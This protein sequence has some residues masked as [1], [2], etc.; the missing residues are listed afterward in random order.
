MKLYFQGDS[1]SIRAGL[2]SILSSCNGRDLS[3]SDFIYFFLGL[4]TLHSTGNPINCENMSQIEKKIVRRRD[5]G[6]LIPPYIH[7]GDIVP[8][9]NAALIH[10]GIVLCRTELVPEFSRVD[11]RD[12]HAT[13]AT[14]RAV[15]CLEDKFVSCYFVFRLFNRTC[16]MSAEYFSNVPKLAI[17]IQEYYLTD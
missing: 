17:T 1:V 10:Q 16:A 15:Y 12:E 9:P 11:N 5:L 2:F 8:L 13:R 7:L 3:Q 4:Y 6:T 14:L